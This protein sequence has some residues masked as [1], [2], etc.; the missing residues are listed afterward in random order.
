MLGV[1]G[2]VTEDVVQL[3]FRRSDPRSK[4]EIGVINFDHTIPGGAK[5]YVNPVR[6]QI[7]VRGNIQVTIDRAKQMPI[8]VKEGNLP[9]SVDLKSD[10][11]INSAR[12]SLGELDEGHRPWASVAFPGQKQGSRNGREAANMIQDLLDDYIHEKR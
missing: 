10:S 2:V 3:S 6:A 4:N 9:N 12:Q 8:D 11:I 1:G 7:D 5:V